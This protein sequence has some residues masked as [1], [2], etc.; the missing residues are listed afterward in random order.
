MNPKTGHDP[1]TGGLP[2]NLSLDLRTQRFPR[3]P[4][5]SSWP[6]AGLVA[7]WICASS[8]AGTSEY[9][10]VT[11][12][13]TAPGAV[14]ATGPAARFN[15]P[16]AVALDAAG[17]LYVADSHNHTIRRVTPQGDVTTLA[18]LAGAA[19]SRDG[20]GAE[21]R[22]TGPRGITVDHQGT[23]YVTD[24]QTTVRKISPD[25][26]V[27]TL[28]GT[29]GE[30]GSADGTGSEARFGHLE[31]IAV[32]EA[33]HLY[34]ADAWNQTVRRISA[35]GV[36]TT[37]AGSAGQ[38][39]YRDGVGGEARFA[40][41]WG[42]ALAPEGTLFVGDFG[43]HVVRRI[44]PEGVVTTAAGLP[45]QRG[46]RD[47][48][49]AE[50]RFNWPAGVAVD[51]AGN[52]YVGD[53]E[54]GTHNGAVRKIAADGLVSTLAGEAG[55]SGWADGVGPTARFAAPFGVAVSS[56]GVVYVADAWNC[57]VRQISPEGVVTTL[58]GKS[59]R[60]FL[61]TSGIACDPAGNLLVG[62]AV[63]RALLRVT[64]EGAVTT[65]VAPAPGSEW[66]DGTN[67]STTV[68]L[69]PRCVAVDQGGNT[70]VSDGGYHVVFKVTAEGQ[71]TTLAGQRGE[72]G[73]T[74]GTGSQARFYGPAGG[75]LDR[76]GTLY[77][78]DSVN[79]MVRR[80]SAAGEV[81]T[82][83]GGFL[84][85]A[86]VALD[87]SGAFL[88]VAE[89]LNH[90]IRRVTREGVVT[91]LAGQAGIPGWRDGP[92]EEAQFNGPSGL[93]VDPAGVLYVAD[94]GNLMIRRITP[95]GT[96]VSLA[97]APGELGS[98]DGVGPSV[99][100][101]FPA[102]LALDSASVLYVT[103]TMNHTIRR[104][105][106]SL[107]DLPVVHEGA[108][109]AWGAASFSGRGS[110]SP[111][112]PAASIRVPTGTRLSLGTEPQTASAWQWRLVRRPAGSAA[113]LSAE[114]LSHPTFTPDLADL[115]VFELLATNTAGHA[116]LHE[117]RLVAE[118]EAPVRLT[119]VAWGPDGF[120]VRLPSV[121]GRTYALEYSES[122]EPS[123]WT[124]S[125]PV[126]GTGEPLSLTHSALLGTRRFFRVRVQ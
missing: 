9:A 72:P 116:S 97:G 40:T 51:Q 41:P 89:S 91:T 117:L 15:G 23:V 93:A 119:V 77:L 32:D 75:A 64:P 57:A 30:T 69:M 73:N 60:Q 80:I 48:G 42:V 100:F 70:Y 81:S 95:D 108:P 49:P 31:G 1:A 18:G 104:G 19:G 76:D 82:L 6:A 90:T 101:Y 85:P 124:T 25:R 11:L 3:R 62:D 13:G 16:A 102:N 4:R 45:G 36:V 123:S 21:A 56:A 84:S 98:T 46:A 86:D 43:N 110:P 12:A 26:R 47:G 28:A 2:P 61:G 68:F 65:L 120:T 8:A 37:F 122:L 87:P 126:M 52:L 33:G 44:S 58:A 55:T 103:D 94:Q 53:L 112:E 92:A 14:D 99:R 35:E 50:A 20:V 54:N 27:T 78:A 39:G 34:V 79:G 74:D 111:A 88:Y 96:V 63:N 71:V 113:R 83:A 5:W 66:G 29:F 125:P 115:Y 118:G 106:P 10:F 105:V 38:Y 121:S 7:L 107:P 109:L 17:N 114:H 59:P 67:L 24:G 22:F